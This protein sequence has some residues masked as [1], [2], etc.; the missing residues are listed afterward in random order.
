M[1]FLYRQPETDSE[2]PLYPFALLNIKQCVLKK[3]KFNDDLSFMTSKKHHHNF[4][5]IHIIVKGSQI[6]ETDDKR[7]EVKG[8][9]YLIIP[10]LLRHRIIETQLETIKYSIVFSEEESTT[11]F[12]TVPSEIC[13]STGHLTD[14][15]L[16]NLEFIENIK[17]NQPFYNIITASRTFEIIISLFS[18][19][20]LK[21]EKSVKSI[22]S[23]DPRLLMAKKFIDDN[24]RLH[25]TVTDISSYCHLSNKQLTRLFKQFEGTTP[26]LYIQRKR[27]EH[28]ENLLLEEKLSIKEI[29]ELMNFNNEFYFNSFFKKHNGLPPHA[30]QKMYTKTAAE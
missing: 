22:T 13:C 17:H 8:G 26:L 6:Y 1:K 15:I 7:Y 30:F 16:K 3:M 21:N 4:Y 2:H 11:I 29:S 10:P 19:F 28:I 9:Q 27:C 25:L 5:E 12:E 14:N 23:E 24:I 18:D 20:N